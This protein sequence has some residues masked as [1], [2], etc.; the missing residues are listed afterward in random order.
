M[1]IYYIHHEPSRAGFVSIL[2]D[3]KSFGQAPLPQT[4][5]LMMR[6]H[7]HFEPKNEAAVQAAYDELVQSGQDVT[8]EIR[9]TLIRSLRA[10]SAG[11]SPLISFQF[12]LALP[13]APV[14]VA[15]A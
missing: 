3:M 11:K 7:A 8:D 9:A 1:M 10:S 12:K 6:A 2:N 15:L 14:C 5:D 4:Y 13:N